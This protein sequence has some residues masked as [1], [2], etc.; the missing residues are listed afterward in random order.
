MPGRLGQL[1]SKFDQGRLD[2]A[3]NS[4]SRSHERLFWRWDR[5]LRASLS[6]KALH[7]A[8]PGRIL[9]QVL[10]RRLFNG[11]PD[12][13]VTA[14]QMREHGN[15]APLVGLEQFVEFSQ[16]RLVRDFFERFRVVLSC[17]CAFLSRALRV[18]TWT[19]WTLR[20][21]FRL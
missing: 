15:I 8:W 6:G 2:T 18:R 3:T 1:L 12:K 9:P 21:F 19:A 16:I 11:G 4:L 14:P 10:Y 5:C 20:R 17:S 13:G 7:H